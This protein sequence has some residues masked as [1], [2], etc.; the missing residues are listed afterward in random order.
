MDIIS[1]IV[2]GQEIG[3][4]DEPDFRNEFIENLNAAFGTGWIATAFP[5][6]ATLALWMASE[7]NFIIIPNPLV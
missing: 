1:K 6:L 3:C 2:L 7:T 4:I 5:R